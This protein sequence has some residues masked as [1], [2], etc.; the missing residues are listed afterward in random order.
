MPV[1][2]NCG[3]EIKV[4]KV[5]EEKGTIPVFKRI[6]MKTYLS[7]R[8]AEKHP[9]RQ[10]IRKGKGGVNKGHGVPKK[11]ESAPVIVKKGGISPLK[12]SIL[13]REKQRMDR[14]R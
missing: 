11:V 2:S 4:T 8:V 13:A 1:C 5:K 10:P 6:G 9:P 7:R 14:N 12:R 3:Q